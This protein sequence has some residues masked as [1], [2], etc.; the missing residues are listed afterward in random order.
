M[1]DPSCSHTGRAPAGPSATAAADVGTHSP[2]RVARDHRRGD[3][4]SPAPPPIVERERTKCL[5]GDR[6]SSL[7]KQGTLTAADSRAVEVPVQPL[8]SRDAA[9]YRCEGDCRQQGLWCGRAAAGGSGQN[10]RAAYCTC[11]APC[12]WQEL[13]WS[14]RQRAPHGQWRAGPFGRVACGHPPPALSLRARHR[15]R[16]A[17]AAGPQEAAELEP[18]VHR[19]ALLLS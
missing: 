4:Q 13:G 2:L 15:G 7:A 19:S 9:R 8:R 16:A 5:T 3:A 17:A 12:A 10:P 14:R 18:H 6:H 11:D 1:L